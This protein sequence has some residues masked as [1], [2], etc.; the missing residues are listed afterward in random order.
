MTNLMR[1]HILMS[2]PIAA[3]KRKHWVFHAITGIGSLTKDGV[4]TL[5]I[6][7]TTPAYTGN[8][9]ISAGTLNIAAGSGGFLADTSTVTIV[10]SSVFGLNWSG[11]DTIAA[12]YIAGSPV[13]GTWGASGSGAANIDNTHF[14]GTGVLNVVPEPGSAI[15]LLGGLGMLLGLRRRRA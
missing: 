7:G 2:W 15:S 13:T 5:T 8:T 9:T 12:L 11:T 10:G 3:I 6:S 4:G 1:Y 14:S